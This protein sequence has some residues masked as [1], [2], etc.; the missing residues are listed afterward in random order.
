MM[1]NRTWGSVGGPGFGAMPYLASLARTCG[2]YSDWVQTNA[3]QSSLT[4]YIGLT[5]GIDNL[6]TVN[7]CSPS[8]G[9]SSTDD[10]I[11]RQ[12]RQS[13][14]T[15]R[16]YVGGTS[17]TCNAAGNA[18][19]HIPAL[20]YRGTY[21][22][23]TGTHNDADFCATEVRPLT[24]LDP[25][26]LPTF[27]FITPT[28][29]NDGHDCPND[30]VDAWTREHLGAILAGTDYQAGTTAVFVLWDE[31]RPVPNLLIAPSALPG[32]L[33]A[34][35][36]H[37]DAMRTFEDLLGLPILQQGQLLTATSLRTTAH[38]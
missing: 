1:E 31:S 22:D 15:A 17:T 33:P 27:A 28:L 25:N 16:S 5:S 18:P 9:C 24:E 3:A 34:T 10:N 6:H 20:Y 19:K 29:C 21:Q 36:S 32:P 12:I 26:H 13:G 14:G 4:Q 23:I 8:P 37:A 38:L 11:F 30:T 35:A 2:F 7:D